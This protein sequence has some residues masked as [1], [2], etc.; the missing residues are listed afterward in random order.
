MSQPVILSIII[1][2][3]G[4]EDY[5]QDCIE[6]IFPQ[7]TESIECIIVDDG[8]KDNSMKIVKDYLNE[9]PYADNITIISQANQGL[10]MARN[11]GLAV[12]RGEYV[13]FIDSDDF[14]EPNY[15][16]RILYAI[17]EACDTD[18][19]HFN[20]YIQSSSL[21]LKPLILAENTGLITTDDKYLQ[22][23]F[24]RNKWYAWLRVYK[25]NFLKDFAFPKGYLY[26]DMLSIPFLYR[27]GMKIFE[28]SEPLLT[29]RYRS[30]SITN[31]GV[32][33]RQL[34]SLEYGVMLHREKRDISCF[35]EVYI[36][37]ILGLFETNLK[38]DFKNYLKFL[39]RIKKDRSYLCDKLD[40]IHWKKRLMILKPIT[41]YWY[42]NWLG[43]RFLFDPKYK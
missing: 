24:Q 25:R 35:R 40:N 4:V 27:D 43:L 17:E 21:E 37:I 19:I 10:S 6:S 22:E 36:H 28:L 12:A 9:N 2:V 42:K 23:I 30:S 18:L 14:V 16:S 7:L 3:Y 34:N 11:N 39:N 41:F 32:N 31:S 13:A 29:Y 38:F 8:S 1:P 33:P 20:A 5:I 26:E 15:I